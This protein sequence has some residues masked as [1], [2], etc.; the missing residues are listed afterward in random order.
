MVLFWVTLIEAGM[1]GITLAGIVVARWIAVKVECKPNCQL[2]TSE[3]QSSEHGVG[4]QVTVALFRSPHPI[5][6]RFSK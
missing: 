2:P 5:K 4:C 3:V 1:I 6:T